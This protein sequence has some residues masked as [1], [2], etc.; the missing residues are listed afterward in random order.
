MALHAY[1][2]RMIVQNA[3]ATAFEAALAMRTNEIGAVIVTDEDDIVGIVTDRDLAMRVVAEG[4]DPRKTT[5]R[6]VMSPRVATLGPG[7]SV[8]DAL[9]VMQERRLRRI[10]LV[11]RGRAIG[12][13]TLDDLILEGTVGLDEVTAVVRAQIIA[14]GPARTRRFDEWRAMERRY[15][16]ALT[17]W[18]R[19]VA[20]LQSTSELESRE[21]AEDVIELVLR[22]IVQ[23]IEPALADRLTARLPILVQ[24]RLREL[25]PGPD[26]SMTRARIEHDVAELLDVDRAAA[27]AV[28]DD[29]GALLARHV[30][31]TDSV[32]RRLPADLRSIFRR[33]RPPASP[34]RLASGARRAG[35]PAASS[36]SRG[37][38]SAGRAK[39]AKRMR[40]P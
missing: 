36:S 22:A 13:V 1:R 30:D 35:Q 19:L 7:D 33:A 40:A 21:Q 24:A 3:R 17:T 9:R 25:A 26:A 29:V 4:R 5:L 32:G 14:G 2:H 8:A 28:V 10:P 15:A 31:P 38:A 6:E 39:V 34:R 23:R 27:A 37:R 20:R 18:R 11:E 16:R 12:M